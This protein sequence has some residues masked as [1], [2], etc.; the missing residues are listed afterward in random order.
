[1]AIL[2]NDHTHKSLNSFNEHFT[3]FLDFW[4]TVSLPMDDHIQHVH[5][6]MYLNNFWTDTCVFVLVGFWAG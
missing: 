2:R 4:L 1:M 3:I 5:V 6:A